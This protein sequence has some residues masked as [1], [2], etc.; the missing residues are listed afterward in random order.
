MRRLVVGQLIPFFY[1]EFLKP[2]QVDLRY[3]YYALKSSRLERLT[4][5]TSIPGINRDD[6]YSIKIPLLPP[7]QQRRIAAI[8]DK[9]D[10]IRRKRQE[11]L[12]L[13]DEFLRSAFL[14]MFGDPVT[15]PKGWKDVP[16][17]KASSLR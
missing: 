4:I 11:A 17:H 5:T 12:A 9:A 7:S 14:D 6:L 2:G 8:L 16:L 1:T 3:F 13:T 10:A 15:N